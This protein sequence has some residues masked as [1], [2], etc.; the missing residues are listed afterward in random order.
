MNFTNFK[1]RFET[2]HMCNKTFQW[3]RSNVV[4]QSLA[5]M[6]LTVK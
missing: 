3:W 4:H 2:A 6:R 5:E 1:I